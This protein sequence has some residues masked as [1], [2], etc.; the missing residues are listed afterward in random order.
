MKGSLPNFEAG[1]EAVCQ[2]VAFDTRWRRLTKAANTQ[3]DDGSHNQAQRLYAQAIA[4][5]E[6]LFTK[7]LQTG[8]NCRAIPPMMIVS[9]CNMARNYEA[10]PAPHSALSVFHQSLEFLVA[11]LQNG[12]APPP[13]KAEI[14]RNIPQLTCE[15]AARKNM[16]I[17][18]DL[19]IEALLRLAKSKVEAFLKQQ[20]SVCAN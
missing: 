20:M 7:A 2:N 4:E 12:T 15:I 8:E 16:N 9:A 1:T 17:Y 5:A 19:L 10:I 14:V 6:T 11:V 13:L 18:D 3:F